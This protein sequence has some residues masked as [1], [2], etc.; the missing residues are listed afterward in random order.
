MPA[1]LRRRTRTPI[2]S[3]GG[4]QSVQ[5]AARLRAVISVIAIVQAASQPGQVCKES[6]ACKVLQNRG[7][8]DNNELCVTF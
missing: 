5:C 3:A 1:V 6:S 7:K 8:L 2:L 4:V